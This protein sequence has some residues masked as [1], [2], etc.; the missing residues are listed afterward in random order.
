MKRLVIVP[1]VL[2][3][4]FAGGT[5]ALAKLHVAKPGVPHAAG[6]EQIELGD[7]YRGATVFQ[8]ACAGCHGT[9]AEGGV[10]PRLA[11][12]T[13]A[14]DEARRVILG[15]RGVMPARLVDGQRLGDVLAFLASILA[16]PA[17]SS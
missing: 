1:A 4:L 9:Q 10:G 3:S 16:A 12:S 7:A 17:D 11:G 13:I 5:F 15:G 2:F 8:Q 6:G 14:L